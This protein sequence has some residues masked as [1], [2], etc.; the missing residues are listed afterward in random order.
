MPTF[1]IIRALEIVAK[2]A[3]LLAFFSF[4]FSF[5]GDVGAILSTAVSSMNPDLGSIDMG[6]FSKKIGL[7]DFL[8]SLFVVVFSVISLYVS[9]MLSILTFKIFKVIYASAFS[10]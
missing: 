1:N 6:C 10:V 4:I 7:V 5:V 9:T 8:N 3:L 2:T